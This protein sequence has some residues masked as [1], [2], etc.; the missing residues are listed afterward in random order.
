MAV[1]AGGEHGVMDLFVT[2]NVK[3]GA[4]GEGIHVLAA[5]HG[6]WQGAKVGPLVYLIW[7]RRA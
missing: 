4:W 2:E 7:P 5:V 1:A 6:G 3:V